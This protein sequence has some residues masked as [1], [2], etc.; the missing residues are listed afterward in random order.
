MWGRANVNTVL[1]ILCTTCL[2]ACNPKPPNLA[3]NGPVEV[4]IFTPRPADVPASMVFVGQTQS[5]QAVDIRA[6]VNGF[7]IKRNYTE[8][9]RVKKDQL[10][11]EIDH[12]PFLAELESAKAELAMQKARYEKSKANLDRV[13]PLAAE[14]ALSPKDLDNAMGNTK[15]AAASMEAARA[16]V[17]VQELNLSYTYIRSPVDGISDY[18]LLPDGSYVSAGQN[19]LTT[20]STYDPMRVALSVS[21]EQYLGLHTRVESKALRMPENG[22][23]QAGL[24]LADGQAYAH[25]GD[26]TFTSSTFNQKT[27]TFLVRADFPNPKAELRPGQFVRIRLSGAHYTNAIAIPQRAVMHSA[28]GDFV[29]VV[30]AEDKAQVRP[31]TVAD[32]DA[33]M[34]RI[35]SGLK[36]GEQ[37]VVDGNSKLVPGHPLKVVGEAKNHSFPDT[38]VKLTAQ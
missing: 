20:V 38:N 12:A 32:Q 11:F 14:N 16:K 26:V 7:L 29:F 5:A 8:G 21:E 23:L 25:T 24:T 17:K 3:A 19:L 9:A 15:A 33:A 2:A 4:T 35:S 13:G 1:V 6:R 36:G 31:V 10:L 37:V 22:K 18:A 28:K 30:D 27:G 34:W